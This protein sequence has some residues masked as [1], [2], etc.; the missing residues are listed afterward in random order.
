M[1][2]K[3]LPDVINVFG[4]KERQQKHPDDIK[5]TM[6]IQRM[7]CTLFLINNKKLPNNVDNVFFISYARINITN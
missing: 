1:H 6:Y 7:I 2:L 5:C 4:I 3:I